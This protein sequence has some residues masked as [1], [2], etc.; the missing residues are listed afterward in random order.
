MSRWQQLGSEWK[1]EEV[2]RIR[3]LLKTEHIP[4]K[5]PFTDLFFTS[6]F[7]APAEDRRWAILVKT[8][9]LPKA[10]SLLRQ[11]GLAANVP[12]P[13]PKEKAF[14]PSVARSPVSILN[15]EL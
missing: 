9:D 3:E 15:F 12:V 11:E 1:T 10:A 13:A 5:M 14:P 4:F 6:S 8:K 7:H 2:F